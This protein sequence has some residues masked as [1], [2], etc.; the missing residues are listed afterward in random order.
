MRE[1]SETEAGLRLASACCV[2]YILSSYGVRIAKHMCATLM[3]AL[4]L[5][6][7]IT[8]QKCPDYDQLLDVYLVSEQW[9][10]SVFTFCSYCTA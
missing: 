2:A 8:S 6:P 9:R 7:D 5:K 3:Q 10:R 1:E 4:L